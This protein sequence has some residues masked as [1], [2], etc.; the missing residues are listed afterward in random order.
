[1]LV[2]RSIFSVE[3][4]LC[5]HDCLTCLIRLFKAPLILAV[6]DALLVLNEVQQRRRQAG[7]KNGTMEGKKE[8]FNVGVQNFRARKIR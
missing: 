3:K 8:L 4:A 7:S 2:K 6:A 1:M 5:S